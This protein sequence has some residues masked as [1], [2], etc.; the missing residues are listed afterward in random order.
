LAFVDDGQIRL[1]TP[2][3]ELIER[4]RKVSFRLG[5]A[6]APFKSVVSDCRE[7]SEHQIISSNFQI[8][9]QQ[10]KELGAENISDIRLSI[11][12]IAVQVLQGGK[13]CGN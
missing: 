1:R 7:G 2:K 5:A 9:L 8:T 12:E 10:L 6:D 3:E 4:W 13:G 11:E